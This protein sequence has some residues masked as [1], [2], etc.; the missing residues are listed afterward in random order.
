MSELKRNQFVAVL[1]NDKTY[2]ICKVLQNTRGSRSTTFKGAWL[3]TQDGR[4]YLMDCQANLVPKAS[5]VRRIRLKK[6]SGGLFELPPKVKLSLDQM[7]NHDDEDFV[8]TG[9]LDHQAKKRKKK[10]NPRNPSSIAAKKLKV[11]DHKNDPNW[12][13]KIRSDISVWD[14]DPLFEELDQEVPFVS[15]S[16]NSH[17]VTRAVLNNDLGLLKKSLED[18]KTICSISKPRSIAV[19]TTPIG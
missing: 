11:V 13:L 18:R 8:K 1:G 15:T 14:K 3:E 17:L 6:L 4:T 5:V 12:R 2:W 10:V 7:F 9:D 19:N 16:A